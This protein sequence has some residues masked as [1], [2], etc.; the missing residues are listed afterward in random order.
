MSKNPL[1]SHFST[2]FSH[3]KSIFKYLGLGVVEGRGL[4]KSEVQETFARD[5]PMGELLI[6]GAGVSCGYHNRPELTAA[7][8]RRCL[9]SSSGKETVLYKTGDSR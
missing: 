2:L 7:R 3:F 1:L 6:G 5:G 8:F 4:H 9:D